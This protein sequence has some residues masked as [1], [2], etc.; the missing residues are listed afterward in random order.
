MK[1]LSALREKY[2]RELNDVDKVHEYTLEEIRI[3]DGREWDRDLPQPIMKCFICRERFDA[4]SKA[5]MAL[6]C[7]HNACKS[8]IVEKESKK[9]KIEC[10]YD[11]CVIDGMYEVH[12]NTAILKKLMKE[13]EVALKLQM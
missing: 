4:I 6:P 2:Y 3:K 13:A 5:P 9:E 8:C 7:G 1:R 11:Q 12:P 10:H